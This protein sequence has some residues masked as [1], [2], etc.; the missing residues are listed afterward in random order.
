VR[1]FTR[2]EPGTRRSARLA[3][4]NSVIVEREILSRLGVILGSE[5]DYRAWAVCAYYARANWVLRC[6]VVDRLGSIRPRM[7]RRSSGPVSSPRGKPRLPRRAV[8][9]SAGIQV[10]LV[11]S[12]IFGATAVGVAPAV[13]GPQATVLSSWTRQALPSGLDHLVLR[14][15][16]CGSSGKHCV[17][18]GIYCSPGGCGGLIP[19]GILTTANG[20]SWRSRPV[21]SR[22][23][24]LSAVSCPSALECVVAGDQGPLGPKASGAFLVTRNGGANWSVVAV[25]GTFGL[26]GVSCPTISTCFAVGYTTSG[27]AGVVLV[28]RNGGERWRKQSVPAGI[29]GLTGISCPST[30]TCFAVGYADAAGVAL[31][32]GN[33]GKQWRKESAPAGIS[34]ISCPSRTRCVAVGASASGTSGLIVATTNGS[35]QWRKESVPAGI[36]ELAGI[37]CP[38]TALCFAVGASASGAHAIVATVNGGK[39]WT[40][41]SVPAGRGSLSGVSCTPAAMC[42]AVGE[43]LK[44]AHGTPTDNGP[45]V[46][47]NQPR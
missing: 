44:P 40:R 9:W 16:S 21:P 17:A 7:G 25:P 45:Y 28:T 8:C 5:A 24:L 10:F 31:V 12:V 30:S 33:G 27:T 34:S 20:F 14:G 42:V 4:R 47:S 23:G 46:L 37:S 39:A 29:S 1:K 41:D 2:R 11:V 43:W 15:V 26:D 6:A 36:S 19:S 3:S 32:T 35:K 13:A 38:S 18:V 22:I